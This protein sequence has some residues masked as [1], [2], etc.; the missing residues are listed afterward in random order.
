MEAS[1]AVTSLPPLAETSEPSADGDCHTS[2]GDTGSAVAGCPAHRDTCQA[3]PIGFKHGINFCLPIEISPQT[4]L[5]RI[6]HEETNRCRCDI[7]G[8]VRP[9]TELTVPL[10]GSTQLLPAAPGEGGFGSRAV[11]MPAGETAPIIWLPWENPELALSIGCAGEVR[12]AVGRGC[13]PGV[14]TSHWHPLPSPC[15]VLDTCSG[16]PPKHF[17]IQLQ[18]PKTLC[19]C[20]HLHLKHPPPLLGP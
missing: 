2:S 10:E 16:F 9:L 18:K 13:V 14:G 3:P 4:T 8:F 5:L 11:L 7:S 17:E 12:A 6:Q 19:G 15:R 20:P 1:L